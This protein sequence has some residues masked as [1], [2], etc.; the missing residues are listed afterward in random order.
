M[1]AQQWQD[2]L[3]II[4]GEK[5]SQ[6]SIGFIIDSPW[7]PGWYGIP[8][9]SYYT[10]DELWFEA[11]KKAIE[12]FPDA[13]FL[14][15]FWSEYGMCSEPSA[16][17][18]K[19]VWNA[20]NLPH[21]ERVIH[22][23]EDIALLKKPNPATDGMLP[24]I[25]QRLVSKQPQIQQIG[26]QI[27]FAVARGPLNIATFLMGTTEFMMALMMNPEEVHQLLKTITD[28]TVDWL[29]LQKETFPTIEGILLL[30][31]IVGFVGEDECREFAL[32]YLKQAFSA[33]ETK[34]RFFHNDAKGLVSTPF[35]KEIGVNL[36]NFSFEHSI[37]EIAELAG[38]GIVLLG[39]LPP[40][41]VMAAGTPEDVRRESRKMVSEVVDKTRVLWSVG[42]GMPQNVPTE[43]IR[44]FIDTIKK[45][46]DVE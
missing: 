28:F 29:R 40:R 13:M 17:G 8:A 34:V 7:L 32:P 43:N 30:D 33:F 10:S 20:Y 4:A 41:D 23:V 38:P 21:A 36:F 1:N 15:G 2:L 9:L 19:Q 18:A 35:L 26:H 12:T 25:L 39:N 27:K 44:A 46:M 11:N 31:D 22:H 5:P 42:G 24:F 37:N 6:P 16:F 3:K 45:I 14:P